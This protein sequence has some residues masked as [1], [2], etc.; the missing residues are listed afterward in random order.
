MKKIILLSIALIT[1]IAINLSAQSW[2]EQ[3]SNLTTT[4]YSVSAVNDNVAWTCGASGKVLRTT[5]SGVNWVNASGNI[6]TSAALYNIFA[7]DANIALVT[8]S[9][10][11][12]GS[13]TIYKT[14]NGGVNWAT[15]YTNTAAGAFGDALWM[16]DA[17]TAYYYGDP[18]GGNWDLLK[19]TNG[20]NNW[21]T[22]ATVPTTAA[23]WNNG[24]FFFGNNVWI[25]TNSSFILYSS[26]AGVNW[27]QQTTP[28]ANSYVIWFN[29]ANNG[30]S[31]NTSLYGTTNGGANW[32]N[33]TSPVSGNVSG[34]A[35]NG[36]EWWATTQSTTIYYSSNGGA[37]WTLQYTAPAGN[38]YHLTRA[39][40]GSV[41][42]AVRS[43]G[44]IARY[45]TVIGISTISSEIPSSYELSQNYP[46]PFN[47]VT[48]INFALPKSGLV[49]M[50]VYNT[51]GKE[52]K[53]LVN[54]YKNAGAYVVDFNASNLSSG[55]YYY[56][57]EAGEFTSVKKMI[58]VK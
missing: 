20:G 44:G 10:S 56:K 50:K 24:M 30:L 35:G 12:G 54:E 26:N 8:T 27:V 21:T 16:T 22:W 49:T 37:N 19:S 9:P 2:S 38:N 15:V 25:G 18:I 46:N 58:L 51:L 39:R 3:T 29:N 57:L 55:V 14:S 52:V 5:N 32:A 41:V 34:I 28:S 40:T 48:K 43:N 23:G 1:A 6:P 45:G 42:W 7:W 36:N 13:V 4:L 33:I 11:A 53:T 31:G 17:N 47:P